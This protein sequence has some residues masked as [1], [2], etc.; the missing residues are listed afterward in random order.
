MLDLELMQASTLLRKEIASGFFGVD[1]GGEAP[2][3]YLDLVSEFWIGDWTTLPDG[4]KE[5]T[6][7]KEHG[8]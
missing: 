5:K 1:P 2:F 6:G 7:T 8:P 4:A 3:S